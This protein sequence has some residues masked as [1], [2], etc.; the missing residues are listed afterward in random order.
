MIFILH[1]TRSTDVSFSWMQLFPAQSFTSSS[2]CLRGFPMMPVFFPPLLSMLVLRHVWH[3]Q[4]TVSY[5]LP[6]FSLVTS[7][8]RSRQETPIN[9]CRLLQDKLEETVYRVNWFK[10]EKR[11]LWTN[12]LVVST[13]LA[14]WNLLYLVRIVFFS[15][16]LLYHYASICVVNKTFSNCRTVEK[17]KNYFSH[18]NQT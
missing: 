6:L 16:Y 15:I 12:L 4:N 17:K 7:L 10:K 18:K 5:I 1:S 3:V 2:R 9:L 13:A 14:I 8:I 11:I